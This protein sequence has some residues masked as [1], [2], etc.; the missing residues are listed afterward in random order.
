MQ[1]IPAINCQDFESAKEKLK[2]LK[3]FLPDGAWIQ[4]DAA[5]AVFTFHRT[6]AN[7]EQFP[8]LSSEFPKWQWEIHLMVEHP[9]QVVEAW[10]AAGAKRL[11]V[12]VE[13]LTPETA[14]SIIAAAKQRG[15]SVMLASNPETKPE[16]F[17]PYFG[18]FSEFQVLAVTPGWAGQQFLPVVLEKVRFLRQALPQ[19]LIEVDG[20]INPGAAGMVKAAG[21]NIIVAASYLFE[22]VD[23]AVAF[24][25]LEAA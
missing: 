1:V 19:A 7:V 18:M 25:E 10:L 15:A 22:A 21:A 13:V 2:E 24:K 23:K 14:A 16:T 5:D 11:I 20:G 17:Q 8:L 9:E 6:W 4:L 12:H 3:N